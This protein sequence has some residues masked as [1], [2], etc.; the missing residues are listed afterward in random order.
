M[1]F[2]TTTRTL[3]PGERN[4]PRV[5][6]H[7]PERHPEE[8]QRAYRLRRKRSQ[9]SV[10]ASLRAG[11]HRTPLTLDAKG[12]PT[13]GD[14][15]G[16]WHGQHQATRARKARRAACKTLGIRQLKRAIREVRHAAASADALE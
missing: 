16:Y 5:A 2:S 14:P 9:A 3:N 8:S 6:L 15:R 13:Q 4:E 11:E 7:Q 12:N 1:D 10:A